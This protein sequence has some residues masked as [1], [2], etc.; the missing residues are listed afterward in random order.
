MRILYF[1]SNVEDYLSDGL[2]HGLRAILGDAVVDFPKK[3][4]MYKSY[5]QDKASSLYGRGFS[6]YRTLD[7]ISIDRSDIRNELRSGKFDAI[8]FSDIGRQFEY[9]VT[10]IRWL[11][12]R[13]IAVVDGGD[14]PAAFP[15]PR[16]LWRLP[17]IWTARYRAKHF[18][19]FKREITPATR[20]YYSLKLLPLSLCEKL[21]VIRTLVPISF[22]FPEEKITAPMAK[23][24]RFP[25]HIVDREVALRVGGNVRYAFSDEASYYRDLQQSYYGITSKRAGW[26]CLRHYEIAANGAVPCFRDLQNKPAS[27]AP[28]GLHEDN[29][30]TYRSVD[31]LLHRVDKMSEHE[32]GRLQRGA[33]AW[34]RANTT[35][36]RA[37][38][39]LDELEISG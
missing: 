26:D 21:P 5:P 17:V 16:Q 9:L 18:V 36:M 1:T 35:R 14:S 11:E 33:L 6:L 29:C 3:Y 12:G 23:T 24:K 4:S 32:Y 19:Q 8:V 39:F 20:Q 10:H 30:I 38:A 28:H 7:D 27:C 2:L 37:S 25:A 34:V 13:K 22:S 31:E 15:Y